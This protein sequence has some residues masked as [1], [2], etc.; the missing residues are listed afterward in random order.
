MCLIPALLHILPV[1][2]SCI[3]TVEINNASTSS[4]ITFTTRIVIGKGSVGFACSYQH[5]GKT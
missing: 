3:A 4:T 5:I 1:L 2:A